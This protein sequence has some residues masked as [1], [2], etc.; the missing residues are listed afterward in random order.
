MQPCKVYKKVVYCA[1]P[2]HR[3]K[4]VRKRKVH[5]FLQILIIGENQ[6]W[7][8]PIPFVKKQPLSRKN[9]EESHRISW[10]L[11]ESCRT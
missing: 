11:A 9:L 3:H 2:S 4:G 7:A 5:F 6:T 10:N 1:L 8:K